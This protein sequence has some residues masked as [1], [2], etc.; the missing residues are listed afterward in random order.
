MN[1]FECF[2]LWAR[3]T[4]GAD[5]KN[6][7]TPPSDHLRKLF[8]GKQLTEFSGTRGGHGRGGIRWE[9]GWSGTKKSTGKFHR[10]PALV[11]SMILIADSI[12]S[13]T[14]LKGTLL[15]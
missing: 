10:P 7:S 9:Q 5:L 11:A 8:E 13:F 1:I 14:D 4:E 6:A 12:Y 3:L 2:E 15:Y